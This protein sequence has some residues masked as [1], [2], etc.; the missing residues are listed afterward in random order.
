M[1]EICEGRCVRHTA[2]TPGLLVVR[3][4]IVCNRINRDGGQE[5]VFVVGPNIHYQSSGYPLSLGHSACNPVVGWLVCTSSLYQVSKHTLAP[6]CSMY[7]LALFSLAYSVQFGTILS[8]HDIMRFSKTISRLRTP[9]TMKT[10]EH[11]SYNERGQ[12]RTGDILCPLM[13]VRQI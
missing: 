6:C 12:V 5:S 1:H 7:L 4:T 11:K 8:D 9:K 13:N 3:F 10:E 2:C